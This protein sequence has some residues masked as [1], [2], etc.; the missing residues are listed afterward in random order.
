MMKSMKN[1]T[2]LKTLNRIYNKGKTKILGRNL[3]Q[4]FQG[5]QYLI[6]YMDYSIK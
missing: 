5:E 6:N 2:E 1:P 4:Y 3:V